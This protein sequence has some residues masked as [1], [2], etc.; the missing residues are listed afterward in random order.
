MLPQPGVNPPSVDDDERA[1]LVTRAAADPA[2]LSALVAIFRNNCRDGS[3][4]TQEWSAA[5][6]EAM[7]RQVL[8]HMSDAAAFPQ[9]E[10]GGVRF[11]LE[12]GNPE[13]PW[14]LTLWGSVWDEDEE[15]WRRVG[16]V[17]LGGSPT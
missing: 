17:P 8:D 10:R 16:R 14:A 2:V 9:V 15:V 6:M 5:R 11:D 4:T 3:A 1:E 7:A 12:V 13:S